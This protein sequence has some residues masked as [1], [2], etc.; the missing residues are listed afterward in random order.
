LDKRRIYFTISLLIIVAG[1]ISLSLRGL[2]FGIDFKGGTSWQIPSQS[3]S[4]SK[5][6]AVLRSAG[7]SQ[8][9]VVALG[10]SQGR[11]IE[12]EADLSKLSV[13]VRT[14]KEYSV[15]AALARAAG[16]KPSVVSISDVGP[17]WGSQV[18][19]KALLALGFFFVG[20]ALYISL[21]F[22]WKMAGAALI[23]VVHDL[24]VT[25]GIYS[26]ANFQITPDTVIAILT[27]L[28]YSLYDT[29]VVFDRVGENTKAL[30]NKGRMSYSE[31]VNL[32]LN[33]VFMRSVN[34]SL[35]AIIPVLSILVIG[36]Y[37]LGA[38]TLR[39]FGLALF[40]GLTT[41]AYSSIGIASP[42]L[43]IFKEREPKYA[44]LK[45]RLRNAEKSIVMTP[46]LAAMAGAGGSSIGANGGV[47][48][49][50]APIRPRSAP[51]KVS[52]KRRPSSARRP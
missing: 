45:A 26:I 20:I 52:S 2:N 5:T 21:R 19:S 29:I 44:D 22:E 38:T 14:A 18:T 9:T 27:I 28:G 43:A 47:S 41:G 15:G 48:G 16:L 37:V 12:A 51:R 49:G 17:T 33:Q 42:L 23:A 10:S 7:I 32:S 36:A 8:S 40:V 39:D 24:L 35:V 1:A 11:T 6:E 34:T 25:V 50:P 3:L 30:V 4:I 46:R 13:S 31:S